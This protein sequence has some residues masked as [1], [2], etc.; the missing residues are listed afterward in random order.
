MTGTEQ[1]R[2]WKDPDSRDG[3]DDDHPAGR[4][5][6]HRASRV[7]LRAAMLGLA[8]ATVLTL[9]ETSEAVVTANG[10]DTLGLDTAAFGQSLDGLDGA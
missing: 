6:L 1:V 7:G 9:P 4:I 5:T 8:A 10:F 3:A 2:G